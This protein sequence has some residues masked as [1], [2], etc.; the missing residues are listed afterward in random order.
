MLINYLKQK[1]TLL[2]EK[3]M[4][5][6]TP[7]GLHIY[8]QHP[9][10][11]VDVEPAVLSNPSGLLLPAAPPPAPTVIGKVAAVTVKPVVAKGEAV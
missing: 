11:N 8:F 5:F 3:E 6:Y 2:N 9:V 1:Q 7:T 10:E 4:D